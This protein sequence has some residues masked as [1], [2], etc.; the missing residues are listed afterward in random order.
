MLNLMEVPWNDKYFAEIG[1]WH[2][3]FWVNENLFIIYDCLMT[4][5][6]TSSCSSKA[7][8]LPIAGKFWVRSSLVIVLLV[9]QLCR[10]W[11]F[12]CNVPSCRWNQLHQWG[13]FWCRN[14]WEVFIQKN[15]M[16][17]RALEGVPTKWLCRAMFWKWEYKFVGRLVFCK[18]DRFEENISSFFRYVS[19]NNEIFTCKVRFF[20][21]LPFIMISKQ[22]NIRFLLYYWG[23]P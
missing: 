19:I 6:S 17:N 12:T 18:N 11:L 22:N 23:S 13:G 14:G 16:E 2:F 15:E 5:F 1:S 20:S 7:A 10:S 8:L 21:F 3:I 4:L 9:I